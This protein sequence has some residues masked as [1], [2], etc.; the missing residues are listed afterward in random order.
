MKKILVCTVVL[1]GLVITTTTPATT[2]ENP[3]TNMAVIDWGAK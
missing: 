1:L 3:D 2:G